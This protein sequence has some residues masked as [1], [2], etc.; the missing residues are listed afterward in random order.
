MN[1][2][3]TPLFD[4][5]AAAPDRQ[6]ILATV[7]ETEGPSY[8]KP[9]AMMLIDA[10][11]NATGLVSGGC[12]ET[13]LRL[14]GESVLKTGQ[15][16]LVTYDL[17]EDDDALWG[18]GIGCQ[19]VI[20]LHL[21]R[22]EAANGYGGLADI[23]PH[24]RAGR[25]C[26]LTKSMPDELAFP[27]TNQVVI[28]AAA[29]TEADTESVTLRRTDAGCKLCTR[30]EPPT[31]LLICGAGPDVPPLVSLAAQC[32][33]WIAVYDHRPAYAYPGHFAGADRVFCA[34]P[35]QLLDHVSDCDAA[36]VMSHHLLSDIEYARQLAASSARY[37]GL[38]GPAARRIEIIH[39]ANVGDDARYRGPAGLDIGSDLPETIALSILA[40]AHA[41]LNGGDGSSLTAYG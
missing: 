41:V 28:K 5:I 17:R 1:L 26:Q 35:E 40:E 23:E 11:G 4:A 29:N 27:S 20:H 8:R 3:L 22:A 18:L 16:K 25:W 9:G 37:V 39:K 13:D 31:R 15:R 7:T 30:I 34:R 14:Q 21:E 6:F 32:G 19:G 10:D 2:G 36:V 24:W 12:L 38:L 33:W